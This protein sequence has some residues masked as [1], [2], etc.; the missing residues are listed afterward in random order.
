MIE[1]NDSLIPV[2]IVKMTDLN[3]G[4]VLFEKHNMI[5]Y[6]GRRAIFRQFI[7]NTSKLNDN[8]TD[9]TISKTNIFYLSSLVFGSGSSQT[10]PDMK[11]SNIEEIDKT[12]YQYKISSVTNITI[13]DSATES[14]YIK[15]SQLV[16]GT[17]TSAVLRE[18]A[19]FGK[20]GTAVLDNNSDFLFSRI[21]FDPIPIDSSSKFSL[22]YYIYF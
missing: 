19:I 9:T 6:E 18:L 16:A 12:N 10:T 1:N 20:Y 15:F 3:T 17:T 7:K 11:V 22:D 5:T 8:I 14:C 13:N 2:G 21:S 4:K